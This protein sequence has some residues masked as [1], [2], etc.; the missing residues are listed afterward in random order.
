VRGLAVV[1]ARRSIMLSQERPSL[2][3]VTRTNDR[4]VHE[5]RNVIHVLPSVCVAN[6]Q[7]P[8]HRLRTYQIPLANRRRL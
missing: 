2:Q 6:H 1:P 5:R 7:V 8:C 4:H 3:D